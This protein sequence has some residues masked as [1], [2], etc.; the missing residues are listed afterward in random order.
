MIIISPTSKVIPP[1]P[2]LN[3]LF[4]MSA[5]VCLFSACS[6]LTPKTAESVTSLISEHQYEKALSLY[7]KIPVPEQELIDLEKLKKEQDQYLNKLILEANKEKNKNNFNEAENILN[8]GQ[9]NVP[10]SK[11]IEQAIQ[12][13][14]KVKQTYTDKYQLQYDEEYAKFLSKESPLLE[15]LEKTQSSDRKFTRHYKT[16]I[17]ERQR[18]SVIMGES[19]IAALN[20]GHIKT[21]KRQLVLAQSLNN[22]DRWQQ[23]LKSIQKKT[24]S[25]ANKRK[26]KIAK[27]KNKH[28]R[29]KELVIQQQQL[30][31]K[32]LKSRFD[33][34]L[35]LAQIVKAQS[36]IL[37]IERKDSSNN[38]QEWLT[39]SRKN[40]NQAISAQL[41]IDLRQGKVFYSKGKIDEAIGVWKS[42]QAYAPD[43]TELAEH[44]RRAETFQARY[45]S[46][47]K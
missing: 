30:K 16:Q 28:A 27:Q 39:K 17:S 19:G 6:V 42:A 20:A 41:A 18:L 37:D 45:K 13:L 5:A 24:Y 32:N 15:K 22:D 26:R 1:Q 47:N 35:S 9:D 43:N 40:L 3:K 7:E 34:Q 25:Q 8:N 2:R 4:M 33:N 44:I 11:K 14:E 38:E 23:A 36:T 46:L 31:L 10:S 12:S 21:A 29:Q